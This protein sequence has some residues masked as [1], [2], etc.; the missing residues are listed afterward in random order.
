MDIGD[1]Q[2]RHDLS[3]FKTSYLRKLSDQTYRVLDTANDV[4]GRGR[5]VPSDVG[6][7]SS[8]SASAAAV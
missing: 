1:R 5:I 6:K 8:I 3:V 7:I 2:H 4:I